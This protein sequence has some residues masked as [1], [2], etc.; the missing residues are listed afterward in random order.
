MVAGVDCDRRPFRND[1][2]GSGPVQIP[3]LNI[4][5]SNPSAVVITGTGSFAN[6]TD[7]TT[8]A[9]FGVDLVNFFTA[10][11]SIG[12]QAAGGSPSLQPFTGGN[13]YD[14]Y[15]SDTYQATG[16]ALLDLNLYSSGASGQ[17]FTSFAQA[18]NTGTEV[19][20]LS[21]FLA[22][23]PAL[24]AGGSIYAGNLAGQGNG[25]IIGR[26]AVTAV[27]EPSVI[28]QL[29]LGTMVFAGLAFIRHA[30]RVAASR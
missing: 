22:A 5:E 16:G 21:A 26:W 8:T 6:G 9:N 28:A 13:V 17:T 11:V 1:I 30:R 24:N 20:D 29:A 25:T 27:P 3:I 4:D 7:G 12:T 23:L 18:F 19:I 15:N 14:R 2:P 10:P